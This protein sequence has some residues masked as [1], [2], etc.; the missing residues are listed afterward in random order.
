MR[1]LDTE[2]RRRGCSSECRGARDPACLCVC[3]RERERERERE[4]KES[5]WEKEREQQEVKGEGVCFAV[6]VVELLFGAAI[7]VDVELVG[8]E[9][10][11]LS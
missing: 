5:N 3:V 8:T 11:S 2:A 1:A 7:V 10:S 9:S 6:V 4:C